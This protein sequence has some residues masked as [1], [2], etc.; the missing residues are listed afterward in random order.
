MSEQRIKERGPLPFELAA[1]SSPAAEAPQSRSVLNSLGALAQSVQRKRTAERLYRNRLNWVHKDHGKLLAT[2]T[3]KR[4][5]GMLPQLEA[6]AQASFGDRSWGPALLVPTAG[7]GEFVEGWVSENWYRMERDQEVNSSITGLT[8]CRS[9]QLSLFGP[10]IVPDLACRVGGVWRSPRGEPLT[11]EDLPAILFGASDRVCVKLDS[12]TFGRGVWVE[13]RESFRSERYRNAPN[14]VVQPFIEQPQW[15]ANISPGGLATFR[16]LTAAPVGE[17]ARHIFTYV[18]LARAGGD[19]LRTAHSLRAPL[20]T[21]GRLR[22]RA[23]DTSLQPH[24]EH[25]DTGA[26]FEGLA[27]RDHS[28]LV[29]ICLT[30]HE[31]VRQIRLIGWD[32]GFDVAERP[33]L[34]EWNSRPGIDFP[35]MIKGALLDGTGIHPHR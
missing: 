12:S 26:R 17:P 5:M 32:I 30:L 14:L 27:L 9:F 15:L 11:E 25:P 4:A 35:Q 13:T 33:H 23:Y 18:R 10:E 22:D 3:G 6:Y 31:R 20:E 19:V 1:G 16:I 8:S 28:R 2:P 34:I 7:R 29:Q 21:D 24:R